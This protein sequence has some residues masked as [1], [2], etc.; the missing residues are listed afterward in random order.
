LL[1]SRGAGPSFLDPPWP[2]VDE[3]VDRGL[4]TPPA[5]VRT[6]LKRM[7]AIDR[8]PTPGQYHAGFRQSC[9]PEDT[10]REEWGSRRVSH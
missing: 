3:A 8:T 7:C 1:S 5:E 10:R 6:E 9:L 4:A 2:A